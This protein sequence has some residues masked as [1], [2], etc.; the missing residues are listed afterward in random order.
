MAEGKSGNKIKELRIAHCPNI[1]YCALKTVVEC[2]PNLEVFEFHNCSDT[3]GI[4][5][6]LNN[7]QMHLFHE[8]PT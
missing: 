6:V 8:A 1:T 4:S 7:K 3:A 5:N 2:C